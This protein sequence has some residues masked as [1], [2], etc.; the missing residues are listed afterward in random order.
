MITKKTV[1][2]N[3]KS[4][5]IYTLYD[6]KGGEADI[7]TLGAR[8]IRLTA[9]DRDGVYENVVIGAADPLDYVDA[10]GYYGA[11]I[12]R[13]G[14]RIGGA[15]YTLDG[16]TVTLEKNERGNQLHGGKGGFHTKTF[17]AKIDGDTLNLSYF[18]PDGEMGFP[19]NLNFTVSY[20]YLDGA[21]SIEYRATSDADTAA[22]FTNH[23][24][25][26]LGGERSETI[27]D[28]SLFIAADFITTVDKELIPDGGLLDIDGTALNFNG[29]PVGRGIT[30]GHELLRQCNGYDF[31]YCLRTETRDGKTPAA[32]L[33]EPDSGR[34]MTVFTDQPGIQ[35]YTS[36]SPHNFPSAALCV[37]RALCLETQGF[38]D[39]PNHGQFPSCILKKDTPFYSKTVYSF[40]IGQK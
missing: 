39:A 9:A 25:F 37:Y 17:E 12:G 23:A 4:V 11:T 33:F 21:L 6:G 2:K 1:E 10:P 30:D 28:H 8:L 18:S 38:P 40:G 3:G 14:N 13:Y 35:L 29:K 31:N 20:T 22:N 5:E 24:Y 15:T 26:N 7:I 16:N 27:L 19:G 36:N 32:R 34:T